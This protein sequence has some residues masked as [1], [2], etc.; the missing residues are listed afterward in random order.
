MAERPVVLPSGQEQAMPIT[1]FLTGRHFDGETKR[2]MGLAFV[3]ACKSLRLEDRNDDMNTVVA[4][5]IIEI[6]QQGGECDSNALCDKTLSA[7]SEQSRR[8]ESFTSEA[9]TPSAG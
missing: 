3:M 7:L 8:G 9:S 6:V 2:V 5:K 1:P 4:E